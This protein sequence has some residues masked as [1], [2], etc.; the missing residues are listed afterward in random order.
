MS[1]GRSRTSM[2][3]VAADP[4]T[5][6]TAFT[7]EL[8]LWWVRGPINAYDSGRLVEMRCERGVGGRIME[9][10]DAESGEGLEL[11]RITV[12]EAGKRLA[13][14]S[15]LDDVT[16]DVLFEPTATGT[17][18]RLEATVS[19]RRRRPR[20]L[21]VRLGDTLVVRRVDGQARHGASR[22]PRPRPGRSHP[23]L[24]SAGRRVPLARRGVR[25]RVAER[26]AGGRG[27]A[28]RRRVRVSLDRVP[29]RQQLAHDRAA[30][31]SSGSRT[32][33]ACAMGVR[34]RPRGTPRSCPRE[35]GDDRAGHRASRLHV[36]HRAR[37]RA[38]SLALFPSSPDPAAL[39]ATVTPRVL[40]G[41][42]ADDMQFETAGQQT[43]S[44]RL[45]T[46]WL[47]HAESIRQKPGNPGHD[48]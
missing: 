42:P 21:V 37:P 13:W 16:I 25:L 24:R 18:V 12:W 28:L 10:Y 2:V 32:G 40:L 35:R 36:V 26:P 47:D 33:H 15:T 30:R 46:P 39:S 27:S 22:G 20:R 3:E 7:D 19:E 1:Q 44:K 29:R 17:M 23:P 41:A 5:D 9:V 14:K 48:P 4:L 11:A 38:T 34:G 6:F 31:R 43:G 45:R 8:D